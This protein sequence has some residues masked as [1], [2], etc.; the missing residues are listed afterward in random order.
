[1]NDN[2]PSE[3]SLL[4]AGMLVLFGYGL[5]AAGFGYYLGISSM[6]KEA[7]LKG[8]AEYQPDKDGSAVFQWKK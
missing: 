6:K 2:K 7:V 4:I 8:H 3:N 1:M 5:F